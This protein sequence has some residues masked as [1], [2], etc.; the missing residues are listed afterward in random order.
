MSIEPLKEFPWDA[1]CP[2]ASH[3]GHRPVAPLSSTFT[4][5]PVIIENDAFVND[6]LI[7]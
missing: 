2:A 3:C 7:P 6:I 5:A 1:I 4:G